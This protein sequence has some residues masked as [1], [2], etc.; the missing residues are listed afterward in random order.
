MVCCF[1]LGS[2]A[3]NPPSPLLPLHCRHPSIRTLGERFSLG[4]SWVFSFSAGAATCL[5]TCLPSSRMEVGQ[6][7]DAVTGTRLWASAVLRSTRLLP[8]SSA[9]YCAAARRLLHCPTADAAG[10]PVCGRSQ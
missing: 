9:S 8:P 6:A 3:R 4:A 2:L 5:A 1:L 10:P 7:I